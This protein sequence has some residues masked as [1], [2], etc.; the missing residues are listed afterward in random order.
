MKLPSSVQKSLKQNNYNTTVVNLLSEEL[1]GEKLRY[2][3]HHSYTNKNKYI[4]RDIAVEFETLATTLDTF[5]NHSSK[6]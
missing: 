1:D 2:G 6:L 3:L 5:V 4:K